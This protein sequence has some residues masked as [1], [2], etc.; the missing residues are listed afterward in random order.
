MG[1]NRAYFSYEFTVSSDYIDNLSASKLTNVQTLR[2]HCIPSDRSYT[3]NLNY[4]EKGDSLILKD[5]KSPRQIEFI[6]KN[7]TKSKSKGRTLLIY[8]S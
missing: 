6:I 4:L 8:I 7:T 1:R 3:N 5:E 2:R